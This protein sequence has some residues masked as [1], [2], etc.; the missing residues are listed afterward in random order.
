MRRPPPL[1]AIL[2]AS[3]I[4]LAAL[5]GVSECGGPKNGHSAAKK[6]RDPQSEFAST[7]N[8]GAFGTTTQ[9]NCA[10]GKSL[11]VSGSN[12]T[13]TVRGHCRLVNVLGAD[14]KIAIDQVDR[15]LT[16]TGLNNTVTYRSGTPQVEDH[17]SGN[18]IRRR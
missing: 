11:N 6:V 12:N 5:T 18:T 16:I 4:T 14:N 9:V 3:A 8:Y 13:L 10:D 15:I 1:L 2:G 17:G 7:I